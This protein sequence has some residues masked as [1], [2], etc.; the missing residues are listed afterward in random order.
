MDSNESV[1]IGVT[2]V[3]GLLWVFWKARHDRLGRSSF[4]APPPKPDEFVLEPIDTTKKWQY[5][6]LAA[7]VVWAFGAFDFIPRDAPQPLN[8]FSIIGLLAFAVAALIVGWVA[9]TRS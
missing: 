4:P 8:L 9:H 3:V 5:G 7:G 6:L 2:I 1:V